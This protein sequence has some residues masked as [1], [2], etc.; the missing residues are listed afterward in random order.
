M[1]DREIILAKAGALQKHLRRI[2]AKAGIGLAAFLKDP[3]SQ[4]VALFNVQMAIQ[5]CIDI[6]AHIISDHGLGVPGSYNEMFYILEA[7]GYLNQELTE[8]MVIAI[9][10]RNLIVHEY[11]TLEIDR[12]HHIINKDILDL[13]EYIKAILTRCD[14]AG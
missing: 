8:K 1:V 9:G 3:D 11:A 10:F 14:I 7:N 2:E 4:D 5:N 12:L 6:A 13:N